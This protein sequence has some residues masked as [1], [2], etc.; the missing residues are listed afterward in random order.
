MEI[1]DLIGTEAVYIALS[2]YSTHAVSVGST[3]G[4]SGPGNYNYVMQEAIASDKHYQLAMVQC[5]CIFFLNSLCVVCIH[6][7][8][9][10]YY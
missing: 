3:S 5:I 10:Y 1:D 2:I 6:K 4:W 8:Y 9:Y 7:S